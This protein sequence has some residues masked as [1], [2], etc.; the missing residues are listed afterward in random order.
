MKIPFHALA[1]AAMA[2]GV[3][4]AAGAASAATTTITFDPLA[5][6][7]SDDQFFANYIESGYLFTSDLGLG[8]WGAGPDPTPARYAGSQGLFNAGLNEDFDADAGLTTLTHGGAAFSL[9][10]IDLSLLRN[11]ATIDG[12]ATVSIVFRGTRGDGSQVS[13]EGTDAVE[14]GAFGFRRFDLSALTDVVE[15]HW[16]QTTGWAHQFD[17]LRLSDASGSALPAP[18]TAA[19]AALALAGLALTRGARR[20]A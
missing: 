9:L 1:R 7:S 3:A 4:V 18:G 14:V 17:N 2:L 5:S 15:V 10:S 11:Y 12:T 13:T 20:R 6:Q 16:Q 8:S 19:L